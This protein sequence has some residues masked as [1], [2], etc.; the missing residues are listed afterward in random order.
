VCF[1]PLTFSNLLKQ[2]GVVYMPDPITIGIT[3]VKL[4][5]AAYTAVEG[6]ATA[7]EGVQELSTNNSTSSTDTSN[8]SNTTSQPPS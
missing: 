2:K 1:E 3:V 5:A 8:T 6:A 7:I 4:V